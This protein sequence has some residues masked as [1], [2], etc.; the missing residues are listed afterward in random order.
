MAAAVTCG[1]C[2]TELRDSARFCDR[3]G[4]P[5]TPAS[6]EPAEYKQVTVL[7]AD[8][9]R[10]MRIAAAVEPERYREIMAALVERAAATVEAYGGSVDFTGD[11]VMAVFG[12]P[13]ALEDHALRA[14]LAA[15]EIQQA[16]DILAE[17]VAR[18]DPVDVRV[19]VGLNSGQVIAGEL[20]SRPFGY[21][22]VGEQVGFAQRMES[23]APPGGVMVSESTAR[24]VDDLATLGEPEWV[25]IKGADR[26]VR[27]RRLLKIRPR[28][29]MSGR[30]GPRLV[31]RQRE[32]DAFGAVLERSIGGRGGVVNVV[33][34]AGIGKSRMA[35]ECAAL[36]TARG[37]EVVWT[38]CESHARG[39][40]FRTVASLLRAG[41]GV[42]DLDAPAARA[43]VRLRLGDAA[44]DDL[45][46]LDDLLGIA[47]ADAALPRID[48]DAR[49]RRV[50]T[51]IAAASK[52]RSGSVLFIVEDVHWIDTVS[53]S[54]LADYFSAIVDTPTLV[55]IT[56]RPE[57]RGSL[58]TLPGA[59]HMTLDPLDES[60]STMLVRELLGKD[61]S[62]T[63]LTGLIAERAAGNPFFAEEMVR[64]LEQRGVF[65]GRR[66]DYVSRFDV[67][68]ISVP[69][70]VQAAIEARIDALRSPAKRTLHMAAVIGIRF[71]VD[72][73]DA[74]QDAPRIDELIDAELIDR[75]RS[76]PIEEYAFR[77]PLIRAVAYASQLKSDRAERHQRLAAVIGD[78]G[79]ADEN[80]ALIASH[81]EAAGDLPAAYGWHM[82]SGQWSVTRDLAAARLAWEGAC[83][84]ADA[85]PGDDPEVLA[86]RT[87]PRT[88][89]CTTDWQAW[90]IQDTWGRFAE[91]RTL[92]DAT[93]DKVSLAIG[94]SGLAAE[95]LST[96]GPGEGSRIATEQ[97]ALV[98]SIG[99][100]AL[101]IGLS[102]IAFANWFNGGEFGEIL[103][104]S[105]IVIDLAAGDPAKGAGFGLGSPLA[106]ALAFRA[107]ARWWFGHAG[108]QS[109]LDDALEF[110]RQSDPGTHALVTTWLCGPALLYGVRVADDSLFRILDHAEAQA[111]SAVSDY[112]LKGAHY[113]RILALLFRDDP[114]ERERALTMIAQQSGDIFLHERAPALLPIYEVLVGREQNRRGDL[115]AI[116]VM[117]AAVEVLHRDG[118]VGWGLGPT[119][120]LAETLLERGT[121]ADIA[122]ARSAIDWAA[123]LPTADAAVPA[124][125]LLWLHTLLARAT[126]DTSHYR[127][128]AAQYLEKAK[129][130]GFEGHVRRAEEMH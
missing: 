130:L 11:G 77:H 127:A 111:H 124:I 74:V 129:S 15:L 79:S 83:R 4:A 39:V 55:V 36:A 35:G 94:M 24:L 73:L 70:T 82:R 58:L 102:F 101:S 69:V 66:G 99:D 118:R 60:T 75:V 1:A 121:D 42:A 64:E 57:Y 19:R 88:L 37:V 110:A 31:G 112:G 91:L 72:L 44:T 14:C 122:E 78:G 107:I 120:I 85:M 80:A 38:F 47:D 5:I 30:P 8:V 97:M 29:G 3:C 33:S 104:R 56:S 116:P 45:L 119:A 59:Q 20:G 23:V 105:H 76:H 27:A 117:R 96:G 90:P 13:M 2:G 67:A 62:V 98:D 12:A 126:G 52:T 16:T 26:P 25:Q 41:L 21:T 34:P 7:F 109:D 100:P 28:Q 81:L 63:E 86:M 89:L 68:D 43:R 9:V 92:C 49:R 125:T 108:W 46:L 53:E 61:P 123:H 87:A 84:V 93:G 32:M 40:P 106:M 10:S 50:R 113:M 103:Q 22:T 18:C 95:L 48:P 128:L 71:A 6:A 17:E 54:M 65:T 114:S 115:A 51:L